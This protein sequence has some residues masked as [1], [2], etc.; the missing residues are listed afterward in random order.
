MSRALD[1]KE[2]NATEKARAC[3][4]LYRSVSQAWESAIG[5]GYWPCALPPETFAR[6]YS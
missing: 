5:S 2:E 1:G 3:M 4:D 6:W